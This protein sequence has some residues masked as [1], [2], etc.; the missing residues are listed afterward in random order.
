MI[1]SWNFWNFGN[2][3]VKNWRW[4]ANF[5]PLLPSPMTK[6]EGNQYKMNDFSYSYLNFYGRYLIEHRKNL[7]STPS[8]PC[9]PLRY[10]KSSPKP[11]RSFRN[12]KKEKKYE[13]YESS[14]SRMCYFLKCQFPKQAQL[15]NKSTF[16]STISEDISR[17]LTALVYNVVTIH[18]LR[19]V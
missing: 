6:N 12:L 3:T 19:A 13:N 9:P 4:N 1:V 17:L 7:I 2:E 16:K 8:A 14:S 5:L 15:F 18:A 11:T 10:F